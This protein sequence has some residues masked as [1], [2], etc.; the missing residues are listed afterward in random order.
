MGKLTPGS[1]ETIVWAKGDYNGAMQGRLPFSREQYRCLRSAEIQACLY[2]HQ[3]K[4]AL[5]QTYRLDSMEKIS[6]GYNNLASC[7]W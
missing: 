2:D 7:L 1:S 5:S 3:R 4:L 6:A